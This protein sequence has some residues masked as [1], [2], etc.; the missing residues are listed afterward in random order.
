MAHVPRWEMPPETSVVRIFRRF[1]EDGKVRPAWFFSSLPPSSG[2][3][4][5]AAPLGTCYFASTAVGA[6]LEVFGAIRV[7]AAPDVR[8]RQL[9]TATRTGG[10]LSL[11]DLT[12]PAAAAAGV[13]LDVQSGSDYALPQ[14]VAAAAEEA[15]DAGVR[16]LARHDPSGTERT[17]AVF[18]RAGAPRRQFGW[19][20][21][22]RPVAGDVALMKALAA[23]GIVVREVPHD[24]PVTRPDPSGD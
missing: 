15:G 2:R 20:V 1:D 24:L 8:R 10:P 22:R 3:F 19:K 4:D 11:V 16:A 14:Q 9:A 6:W 5:L 17:V 21:G 12:A 13:T 23:R 7:V 18:G